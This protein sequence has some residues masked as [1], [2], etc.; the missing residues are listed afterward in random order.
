MI[1]F[2]SLLRDRAGIVFPVLALWVLIIMGCAPEKNTSFELFNPANYEKGL[3]TSW[4]GDT[5]II[6]DGAAVVNFSPGKFGSVIAIKPPNGW[7]DGSAYR[8]VRCE[9]ENQGSL[10]QL[11]ELGFGNYDLTLGGTIVP[12]GGK[13]TLKAV[14]YRNHHPAYIDSLFPVMHGKPDGILRS[15]MSCTFDSIEYIKLLFPDPKPA[16]RSKLAEYG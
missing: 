3:I 10:P 4:N 5:V 2:K 1:S 11:V 16:L 8:F 9:I 15:W 12:P 6:K 14:I 13:K 7:W